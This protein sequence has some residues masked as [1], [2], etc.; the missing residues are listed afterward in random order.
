MPSSPR[1]GPARE[2]KEVKVTALVA[3]SMA[4]LIISLIPPYFMIISFALEA[5]PL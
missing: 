1:N 4:P 5:V 2:A 3:T